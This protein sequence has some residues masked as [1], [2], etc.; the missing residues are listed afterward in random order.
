MRSI[1]FDSLNQGRPAVRPMATAA[2]VVAGTDE[3][4]RRAPNPTRPEVPGVPVA[5]ADRVALAPSLAVP[6]TK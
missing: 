1:S 5:G 3:V 6:P 2:P 4:R